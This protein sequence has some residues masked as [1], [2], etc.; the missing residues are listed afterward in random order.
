[1]QQQAEVPVHSPLNTVNAILQGRIDYL[2]HHLDFLEEFE[3]GKVNTEE[4]REYL[5]DVIFYKCRKVEDLKLLVLELKSIFSASLDD[6]K[7]L[8]IVAGRGHNLQT[9]HVLFVHLHIHLNRTS[10]FPLSLLRPD[11]NDKF[12]FK[13]LVKLLTAMLPD[14]RS[15]NTL[16][17]VSTPKMK[18]GKNSPHE[19][20]SYILNFKW[21]PYLKEILALIQRNKP[22]LQ[23][24]SPATEQKYFN[25]AI[26]GLIYC[27][28]VLQLIGIQKQKNGS[29]NGDIP[30]LINDNCALYLRALTTLDE[31]KK[32]EQVVKIIQ[33]DR[34]YAQE[35]H[36]AYDD[37]LR[38][39]D[40][41]ILPLLTELNGFKDH[42]TLVEGNNL[43]PKEY[44]AKLLLEL[45]ELETNIKSLK[46]KWPK[47]RQTDLI[48][49]QIASKLADSISELNKLSTVFTEIE[50]R[51]FTLQEVY[52]QQKAD[53][54]AREEQKQIEL[55]AKQAA[56]LQAFKASKATALQE[57][58]EKVQKA[59]AAKLGGRKQEPRVTEEIEYITY[60]NCD[61][62]TR[63]KQLNTSQLLLLQQI[64]N[65][66]RGCTY[67]A[68]FN[69][70]ENH[71]GGRVLSVGNGSSHRRIILDKYLID[72][73][74]KE[75]GE[76]AFLAHTKATGGMFDPHGK[77]HNPGLVIGFNL[78]LVR[79]VFLKAGITLSVVQSLLATRE[80]NVNEKNAT[81]NIDFIASK[82][83]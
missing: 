77:P 3:K 23:S 42:L 64:H 9:A 53:S 47:E 36:H 30:A 11:F 12:I 68:I 51:F 54:Q 34:K 21:D 80:D 76:P 61:V 41:K 26:K 28:E 32:V 52:E 58:K 45:N 74:S 56:E 35:C 38:A 71:L 65:L 31:F 48:L 5:E 69:L 43:I 46:N 57:Y 72:I 59:R 2:T 81:N 78:R 18:K 10:Q 6:F 1:M 40:A 4:L 67:A 27:L 79:S 16:F 83:C 20:G 63:L 33:Q 82:C 60:K 13:S 7:N 44:T 15:F 8:K 22:S 19:L 39:I 29:Y 70:I 49:D 14:S 25:G 37:A 55:A 73:I 75:S 66:E 50:D 17:D 24:I 62:E